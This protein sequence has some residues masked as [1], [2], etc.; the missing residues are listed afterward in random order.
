MGLGK[1]IG[2]GIAMVVVGGM[3]F[4]LV[5]GLTL[6]AIF[7]LVPLNQVISGAIGG[8]ILLGVFVLIYRRFKR[9]YKEYRA[10]GVSQA[11]KSL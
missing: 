3:L 5:F 1:V 8:F 7:S 4:F 10:S 9:A 6:E 11:R 2:W